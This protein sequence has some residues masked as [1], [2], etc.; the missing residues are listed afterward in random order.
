M[1]ESGTKLTREQKI[2]MARKAIEAGSRGEV[3]PEGFAPDAVMRGSLVGELRGRDAIV[4]ALKKTPTLFEEFRQEPHAILA[5]DDH[6]IALINLKIKKQGQV[7]DAQQV[8]VVH[9][10]DQGQITEIWGMVEP[11]ALK[12]IQGR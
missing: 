10:N 6:V 9:T 8:L 5:D 7:I 1:A 4:G 11:E 3:N 2:E 12:Q